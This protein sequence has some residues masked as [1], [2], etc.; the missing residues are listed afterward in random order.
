MFGQIYLPDPAD[1]DLADPLNKPAVWAKLVDGPQN[2]QLWAEYLGQ[3]WESL[4][5]K[6]I[7]Q[8]R[9]WQSH[10]AIESISNRE[11]IMGQASRFQS[12]ADVSIFSDEFWAIPAIPVK[13]QQVIQDQL[14]ERMRQ[15]QLQFLKG[16]EEIMTS[17]TPQIDVLARNVQ[18]NFIIIE[19]LF[20]EEFLGLGLEYTYYDHQYPQGNYNIDTWVKE[21]LKRLKDLKRQQ[22]KQFEQ[23]F[24]R[25]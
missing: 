14:E 22:F 4:D 3:P 18:A 5:E 23:G 16:A 1:S 19:D 15:E 10:I 2:E 24:G 25:N 11:A 21:Q 13:V 8:V 9:K 17:I 7:R 20:F 12:A 6:A